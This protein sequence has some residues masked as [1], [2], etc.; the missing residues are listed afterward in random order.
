[1]AG[2]AFRDP[3][4]SLLYGDRSSAESRPDALLADVIFKEDTS[5]F[6]CAA[7]I[8]TST[9]GHAL[10]AGPLPEAYARLRGLPEDER[11]YRIGF[12]P[13]AAREPVPDHPTIEDV[14]TRLDL[15]S[16]IWLANAESGQPKR[17][18]IKHAIWANKFRLGYAVADDFLVQ[19][20]N[21]K[22]CIVLLGDAAHIHPPAGGQGL[23]ISVR[24]AVGLGLAF[25]KLNRGDERAL[26]RYM[27]KRHALALELVRNTGRIYKITGQLT[28]LPTLLSWMLLLLLKTIGSISFV[29]NKF[30]WA[31]SGLDDVPTNF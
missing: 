11:I 23:N 8:T 28:V 24:D 25:A 10:L 7:V 1:L 29:K 26:R 30:T 27:D 4:T 19:H 31:L 22:G 13:S 12:P 17:L 18:T 15:T 20:P 3:D 14:Q 16:H 9:R 2:V 5:H 21:G 6:P